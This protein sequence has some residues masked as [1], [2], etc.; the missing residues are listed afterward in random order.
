LISTGGLSGNHRPDRTRRIAG[1]AETA[2]G[3]GN[4]IDRRER[5]ERSATAC[6]RFPNRRRWNF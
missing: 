3:F 5:P 4:G 2:A 1:R 6:Q